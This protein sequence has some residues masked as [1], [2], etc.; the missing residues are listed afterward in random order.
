VNNSVF[1]LL[2]RIRRAHPSACRI[3]AV[4]A[5]DG[6]SL[7]TDGAIDKLQMDHGPAAM[8]VTLAARLNARF[9]PD[10]S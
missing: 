3:F 8:R 5:H 7:R 9:A 4:H 6:R 1:C 10:A 2:D